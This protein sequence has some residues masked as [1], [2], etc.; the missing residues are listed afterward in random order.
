ML[1]HNEVLLRIDNTLR[2]YNDVLPSVHSSARIQSPSGAYF[3]I[4]NATFKN[5]GD[6]FTAGRFDWAIRNI[7]GFLVD[8]PSSNFYTNIVFVRAD[9]TTHAIVFDLTTYSDPAK[10]SLDLPDGKTLN[11]PL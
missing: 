4:V 9:T 3:L 10:I 8:F 11:A 6:N 5:T 7:D 1:E 2:R